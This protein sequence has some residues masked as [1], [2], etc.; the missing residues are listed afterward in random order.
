MAVMRSWMGQ[1]ALAVGWA[2]TECAVAIRPGGVVRESPATGASPPRLLDVVRHAARTRRLSRRTEKAYVAWVRRYLLFHGK[3]HPR[4]L[5]AEA[6]GRFLTWLAVERRVSAS[7][8]NQALGALLF[9]Y[10][11]V[12]AVEVTGLDGVVRAKRSERLPVVLPRPEVQ[13]VLD[14][15]DG[16]PRLMALLLYG[17]GLRV[18]ECARLRVKD[19]DF[20]ASQIVVRGGKGDKDRVTLLP[21]VARGALE[22]QL[23]RVR[24]RHAADVAAGAGWVELRSRWSGSIRTPVGTSGGSGCFRRPG[25]TVRSPGK[26]PAAPASSPRIGAA[27]RGET[28]CS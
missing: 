15:L 20:G 2:N 7:T 22:R 5:D 8:Q 1:A 23:E 21:A 9:L 10:R 13:A 11:H 18:L 19:V 27:T 4:E 12:L 3:R 16:E 28:S 14:R 26:P 24:R 6:I 17:A 25:P